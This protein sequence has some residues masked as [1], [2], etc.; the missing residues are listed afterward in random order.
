[1]ADLEQLLFRSAKLVASSANAL[2]Y[3]KMDLESESDV[4]E[5]DPLLLS[6]RSNTGSPGYSHGDDGDCWIVSRDAPLHCPSRRPEDGLVIDPCGHSTPS[7]LGSPSSSLCSEPGPG[8]QCPA[9][10]FDSHPLGREVLQK[11]Q[12]QIRAFHR[13]AWEKHV[14]AGRQDWTA[15]ISAASAKG[16]VEEAAF[17]ERNHLREQLEWL[18]MPASVRRP[19]YRFGERFYCPNG[20]FPR[21]AVSDPARHRDVVVKRLAHLETRWSGIHEDVDL[22][23]RSGDDISEVMVTLSGMN[24]A[25]EGHQAPEYGIDTTRCDR[26]AAEQ[27]E[28]LGEVAMYGNGYFLKETLPA[29]RH[30]A[31][32]PQGPKLISCTDL[33]ATCRTYDDDDI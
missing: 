33:G 3:S 27:L 13:A 22:A 10:R 25:V 32:L 11:Q 15:E 8:E 9:H 12:Q 5:S 23:I 20:S 29:M 17:L 6:G 16:L 7:V 21:E 19:S 2:D 24:V 28:L 14:T 18:D 26:R 1:M 30:G 4:E 31:H